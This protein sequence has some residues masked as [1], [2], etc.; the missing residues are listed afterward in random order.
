MSLSYEHP[1]R[2]YPAHEEVARGRPARLGLPRS[3]AVVLLLAGGAIGVGTGVLPGPSGPAAA[4]A[5]AADTVVDGC[6]IVAHPTRSHFTDCPGADLAGADLSGLDLS[7]AVLTTANLG[8]ANLT[9]S[10]LRRADLHD[11]TLGSCRFLQPPASD[12]TCD[13]ATV[14]GVDARDV[15]LSGASLIGVAFGADRLSRSNLAGAAFVECVPTPVYPPGCAFASFAGGDL[16]GA[17]LSGSGTS[18]CLT[19]TSPPYFVASYCG[20]VRLASARLVGADL[21]SDD[22]SWTDLQGADLVRASFAGSTFGS[23]APS[24]P[25]NPVCSSA[26]LAGAR[27]ARTSLAG[28][29]LNGVDLQG[30]N[31]AGGDLTATDLSPLPVDGGISQRPSQ[32]DHASFNGVNLTQADLLSATTSGTSFRHAVWSS[33]TCPDGTDSNADGG[34]CAGHLSP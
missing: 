30:A 24:V 17:N 25:A 14:S 6:T 32:L 20:G 1:V 16:V 4:G 11:A 29:H 5:A 26:D 19:L 8:G 22:L 12:F 34:T 10:S 2:T 27:L 33:T 3:L 23:C 21:G 18:E 7:F 13:V 28:L 31:L 9:G 15:D